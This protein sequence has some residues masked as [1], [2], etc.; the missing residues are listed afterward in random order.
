M[1]GYQLVQAI[2]ATAE[3]KINFGEGSIYPVLHRLESEGC[4][5]PRDDEV[6]GRSRVVY[7]TT[8]KGKKRL[9]ASIEE[10]RAVVDAIETVLKAEKPAGC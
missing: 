8:G 10:W 1:Y 3:N 6:N 2:K 9:A 7:R 5:A 4:L